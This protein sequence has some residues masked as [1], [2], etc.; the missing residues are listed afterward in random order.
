MTKPLTHNKHLSLLY[1]CL[2]ISMGRCPRLIQKWADINLGHQDLLQ[3]VSFGCIYLAVDKKD[4]HPHFVWLK[5]FRSE[6]TSSRNF[7]L[8]EGYFFYDGK[9]FHMQVS[10]MSI[11]HI[12]LSKEICQ[13]VKDKSGLLNSNSP[14]VIQQ[15][16]VSGN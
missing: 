6:N 13:Q 12:L 7:V 9:K 8:H 4:R 5:L 3:S 2:H 10:E 14:Q 11:F 16:F 15:S 1:F